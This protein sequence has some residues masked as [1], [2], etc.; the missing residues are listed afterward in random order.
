MPT[1]GI[2][3]KGAPGAE[4]RRSLF[5]RQRFEEGVRGTATQRFEEGARGTTAHRSDADQ[6]TPPH[7]TEDL[8]VLRK[9]LGRS[10]LTKDR[11]DL[12]QS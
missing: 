6:A 3:D 11:I 9:E 12:I 1:G 5:L 2:I 4:Y 7:A 8:A 10:Y